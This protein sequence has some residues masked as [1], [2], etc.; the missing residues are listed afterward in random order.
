MAFGTTFVSPE[1]VLP[2][3]EF[4]KSN[5]KTVIVFD[6]TSLHLVKKFGAELNI[7]ILAFDSMAMEEFMEYVFDEIRPIIWDIENPIK[8]CKLY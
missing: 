5:L 6:Q 2:L 1:L 7:K 8:G 4:D 3:F